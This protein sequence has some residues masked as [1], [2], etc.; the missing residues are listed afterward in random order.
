MKALVRLFR[1]TAFKL[2][3]AYLV[4]FA[5]GAA[6]VLTRV[7]INV[8]D[9]FDEQTAQTID[10]DIRGLAE[11]YAEGGIRQLV[12]VI[13]RRVRTPGASLYLVTTFAGEL[14]VGNI[15]ALPRDLPERSEL[16]E[17]RYQRRGETAAASSRHDAAVRAARR[18]PPAGRP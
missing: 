6:I 7:K 4:L 2:S 12:E 8:E 13:E 18:L 1:T 10:A 11:Q 14:V 17:S 15:A 16:V 5:F 3:L 9:L